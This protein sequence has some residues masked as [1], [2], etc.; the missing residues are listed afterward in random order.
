MSS[1]CSEHAGMCSEIKENTRLTKEIHVALLGEVGSDRTGW[2]PRM[3]SM[4]KT[5]DKARSM[6]FTACVG[7]V[8]VAGGFVWALITGQITVGKP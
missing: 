3:S 6:A 8:S 2:I 4:E 1:T 5:V 7:L